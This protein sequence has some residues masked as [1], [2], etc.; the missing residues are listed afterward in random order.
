M[1]AEE[2]YIGADAGQEEAD[3]VV[4]LCAGVDDALST[5]AKALRG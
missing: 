2:V 5:V 4:D 3:R 1:T